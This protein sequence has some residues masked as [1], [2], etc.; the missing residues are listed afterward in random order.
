MNKIFIIFLS[1]MILILIHSQI[2]FADTLIRGNQLGLAEDDY[3]DSISL[4]E[5][6]ILDNK[7]LEAVYYFS[8]A[9]NAQPTRILSYL[10]LGEIY[11]NNNEYAAAINQLEKGL[12]INR[13][14]VELLELLASVYGEVNENSKAIIILENL[15]EIS[16]DNDQARIQLSRI[17]L[18]EEEYHKASEV[19]ELVS[20]SKDYAYQKN[21]M[22]LFAYGALAKVRQISLIVARH[23]GVFAIIGG[24]V[25][26]L[27]LV[28]LGLIGGLFFTA[29]WIG[30][31]TRHQAIKYKNI[32]W[33]LPQAFFVCIVLFT[34]PLILEVLF[35]RIFFN[36]WLLFLSPTKNIQSSSGQNSLLAQIITVCLTSGMVFWFAIKR[37]GQSLRDLGFRWVKIKKFIL[38]IFKSIIMIFLFNAVYMGVFSILLGDYPEQQFIVEL[39]VKAGNTGQMIGLFLLAVI[40]SPFAEE[41]I[42]RGF[43]YSGL[44]RHCGFVT[45]GI[46]SAFIFGIFHLQGSLF[47]PIGFMGFVFA[48]LFE[49]TRSILP[50][51]IV[52]ML[53]NLIVFLNLISLA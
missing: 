34:L 4:G 26:L 25:I 16:P 13:D 44:R 31:K 38:L 3:A 47:I 35:G 32:H 39:I 53:W 28:S 41:I 11:F 33:S 14:D 18:I 36:N 48:W 27:F 21:S 37:N 7:P 43:I 42:F 6:L 22:L 2:G 52:H 17:L 1:I 30:K 45:A 40:L 12:A 49:R 15:L 20:E 10:K 51:V 23:P 29:F 5:T 8:K 46:I 19:L 50:P 24:L 9:Q